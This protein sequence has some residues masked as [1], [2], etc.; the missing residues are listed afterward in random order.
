MASLPISSFDG[1]R[2]Y[3]WWLEASASAP[4]VVVLHGVKKNRTDVLR[5]ALVWRRAGLNVLVFDG[6]AH[7][8]DERMGV[9]DY[10]NGVEFTYRFMKALGQPKQ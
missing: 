3:G 9:T 5:A 4:T 10:Y 8:K 1:T 2:L 7:G 6:R